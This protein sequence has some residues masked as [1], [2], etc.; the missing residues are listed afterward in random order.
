MK[1]SFPWKRKND[2]TLLELEGLLESTFTPVAPRRGF[3][4]DLRRRLETTM[5]SATSPREKPRTFGQHWTFWGLL[6][7]VGSFLFVLTGFRFFVGIMG[8]LGVLGEFSRRLKK[9]DAPSALTPA[10]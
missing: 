10:T 1:I 6:T 2:E 7:L 3:T 8:A 9:E 4:S 5:P